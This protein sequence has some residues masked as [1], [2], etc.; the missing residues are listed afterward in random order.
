MQKYYFCNGT[1]SIVS[2]ERIFCNGTT[3]NVTATAPVGNYP[4]GVP[5][6]PNGQSVYVTILQ[7]NR[8]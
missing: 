5:I 8:K 4:Y 2:L 1:Y 6:I 7:D 3:N